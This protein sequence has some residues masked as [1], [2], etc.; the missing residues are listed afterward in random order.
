MNII[1]A[2]AKAEDASKFK[3][4]LLRGGF[5]SVTAV[6]SGMQAL[7]AM[8]DLGS[9]VIVCGY[10]LS[11]MLYSELALDLPKFFQ[12][13][14][15]ASPDKAPMDNC[16]EKIVYL[17]TPLKKSDLFS[18]LELMLEGV[19]RS[20]KKAKEKARKAGRSDEEKKI[21]DQAKEILM[22]RHHMTEPEAHKYLQ[23]CAMDSGTSLRET[24][25]MV[26]SLSAI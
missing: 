19:T 20:K 12:M 1:V 7:S 26:I 2:F 21:I 18:T 15:I 13:L 5:E 9:G 23:K 3:S 4:I 22:D 16:G 8:E 10:R 24:A 11:D 25:E 14:M 6:T 17:P